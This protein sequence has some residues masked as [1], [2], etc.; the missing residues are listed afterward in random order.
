MQIHS[1]Y[2]TARDG[3]QACNDANEKA[4]AFLEEHPEYQVQSISTNAWEDEYNESIW[5][6]YVVTMLLLP[7]REEDRRLSACLACGMLIDPDNVCPP[8]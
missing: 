8:R 4:N 7:T 3:Q 2:G 5:T 6:S 1:F